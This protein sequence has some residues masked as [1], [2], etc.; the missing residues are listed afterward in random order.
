M[1]KLQAWI[2]LIL[3]GAVLF[4][5]LPTANEYPTWQRLAISGFAVVVAVVCNYVLLGRKK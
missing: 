4:M 1:T 2:L 3:T 5:A